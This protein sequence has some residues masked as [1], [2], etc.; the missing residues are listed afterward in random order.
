MLL[1]TSELADDMLR[2]HPHE[3]VFISLSSKPQ[4]SL[5]VFTVHLIFPLQFTSRMGLKMK[6]G[7]SKP[8]FI[9]ILIGP[10]FN[11]L[12]PLHD[13]TVLISLE[14]ITFE[15]GLQSEKIWKRNDIV[16]VQTDRSLCKRKLLKTIQQSPQIIQIILTRKQ[17]ISS[18]FYRFQSFS[19]FSCRG[20]KTTENDTKRCSD[21]IQSLRFH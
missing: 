13:V 20:L 6:L 8:L 9:H 5:C 21:A 4:T 3:Y 2:S 15:N 1:M 19:S 11:H 14:T 16:V 10:I 7:P 17:W 18:S 12:S